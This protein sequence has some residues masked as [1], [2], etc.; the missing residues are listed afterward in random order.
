MKITD[1]KLTKPVDKGSIK[2][3]GSFTIDGMFVVHGVKVI[4]T[5]E[6]AFVAMPSRRNSDG[7]FLDICHPI[8]E[9]AR[10]L[11]RDAVFAEYEKIKDET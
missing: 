3:W 1:V 10:E 4:E 5:N 6:K 9:E 2:A 11:I 7:K 8:S